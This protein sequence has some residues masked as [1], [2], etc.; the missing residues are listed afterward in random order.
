MNCFTKE[1]KKASNILFF[2]YGS[3]TRAKLIYQTG[4]K[5]PLN[6]PIAYALLIK[7]IQYD[8]IISFISSI[9]IGNFYNKP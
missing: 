1:F 9:H 4:N 7:C 5:F 6:Y 3:H 8:E 2:F